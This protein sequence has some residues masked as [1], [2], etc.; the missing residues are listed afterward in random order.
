[1][2]Y[3]VQRTYFGDSPEFSAKSVLTA[4][5]GLTQRVN[6]PAY[7][8]LGHALTYEIAHVLLGS[9]QHATGGLMTARWTPATWRRASAGLLVFRHEEIERI[10]TGLR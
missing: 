9:S 4:K 10:R 8:M 5:V 7:V 3:S 1:M 2:F 6:V